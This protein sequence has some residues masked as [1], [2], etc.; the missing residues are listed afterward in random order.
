[1]AQFS[2]GLAGSSL[3][4]GNF[5]AARKRAETMLFRPLWRMAAASLQSVLVAPAGARLW[6]D[7]R[8][9]AFLRDDAAEEAKIRHQD[10]STLET[11][12][13]TGFTPESAIVAITTGDY[14][15]LDHTGVTSIQT[16][17]ANKPA[18]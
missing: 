12:W 2:E 13:R 17:P 14:T 15:Q 8:D 7:T 10:A 18:S 1:M 5:T 9:I 6:Y 11:L 3:N 4:T 16:E